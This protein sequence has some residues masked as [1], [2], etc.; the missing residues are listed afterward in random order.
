MRSA[1]LWCPIARDIR[2]SAGAVW[3]S[4]LVPAEAI[5]T[6]AAE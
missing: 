5:V 3:V 4:C 2:F 1:S 6:A